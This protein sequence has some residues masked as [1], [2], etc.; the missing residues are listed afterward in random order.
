MSEKVM[1]QIA[2]KKLIP[3]NFA[4]E[5]KGNVQGQKISIPFVGIKMQ[6]DKPN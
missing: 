3:R 5:Q 2:I 6:K 4:E 1:Q